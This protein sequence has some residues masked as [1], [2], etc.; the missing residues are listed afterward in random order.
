MRV[1]IDSSGSRAERCALLGI[2]DSDSV[3]NEVANSD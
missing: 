3:I 1:A 2:S